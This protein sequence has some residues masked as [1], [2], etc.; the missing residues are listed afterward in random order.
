MKAALPT[1]TIAVFM[2]IASSTLIRVSNVARAQPKGRILFDET[3]NEYWGSKIGTGYSELAQEL[4]SSGYIV[5]SLA[6]GSI[7]YDKISQY[8]VFAITAPFTPPKSLTG[9]EVQAIKR[10]VNEGG[11]LFLV[12]LGW[13]WVSYAKVSLAL[14]PANQIGNEFGITVNDDIIYDP[15]SNDGDPAR[16]IF[17]EFADH[18][19]TDGLNK[20]WIE[21]PSS[22]SVR[23]NARAVIWGSNASYAQSGSTFTYPRGSRPLCV[24]TSES[25]K[26]RVVYVAHDGIFHNQNLRRYDNLSLALNIFNWLNQ[27]G[28][29]VSRSQPYSGIIIFIIVAVGASGICLFAVKLRRKILSLRKVAPK[30]E[31]VKRAMPKRYEIEVLA[32]DAG[33]LVRLEVEP[34][35]TIE[36]IIGTVARELKLPKA[37][38]SIVYNDAEFTRSKY[39][40]TLNEIGVKEGDTLELKRT[41]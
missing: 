27:T 34:R 24:A 9:D 11:G 26:G 6:T 3:L 4:R 29:P 37:N 7:T 31:A 36:S 13:S 41:T 33:K 39:S 2:L 32:R 25:G 8:G 10:F 17:H 22:L 23:G 40:T 14:N 21:V 30:A 18:P 5:D 15:T 12:A 38:Y 20:V 1:K 16:P 19:V 35:F 28:M